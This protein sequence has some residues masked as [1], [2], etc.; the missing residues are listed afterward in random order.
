MITKM[1]GLRGCGKSGY[2]LQW[3]IFI[4][5]ISLL[6]PP[7]YGELEGA[8][9]LCGR[10]TK[11]G[12]TIEFSENFTSYNLLNE[13]NRICEYC[14]TLARNQE[15]RRKSF[16][17]S[18]EGVRFLSRAECR[19][20]LLS[21]PTPP[22]FIYIT[23]TGQRQG[24]LS[25]IQCVSYSRER[26]WISTDFVGHFLANLQE[27]KRMDGLISELRKAGVS[28]NSLRSGLPSTVEYRKL[29]EKNMTHLLHEIQEY[30]K[31]PSWEVLCYVA[32]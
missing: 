23:Q 4:Y 5:M 13:G 30:V 2:E 22:F 18:K 27:L 12:H 19:K 32:E 6:L 28:K 3:Y 25:A 1:E 8:C 15:F 17:L 14:Y 29:L 24:W 9:V 16:V 20:V 26:F 10:H 21:P 7:T 31:T 11:S